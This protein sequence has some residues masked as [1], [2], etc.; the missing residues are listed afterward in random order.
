MKIFCLCHGCEVLG[1]IECDVSCDIFNQV[2]LHCPLLMTIEILR[3]PLDLFLLYKMYITH[4]EHISHQDEFLN[5]EKSSKG[6]GT[7]VGNVY[8][9]VCL[10]MYL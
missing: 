2:F 5:I 9:Y 6:V 8:D 10:L 4:V 1:G 3:P 7:R